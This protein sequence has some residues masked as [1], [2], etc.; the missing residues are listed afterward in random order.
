MATQTSHNTSKLRVL[1]VDDNAMSRKMLEHRFMRDGH[2]VTSVA[3][4]EEALEIVATGKTDIMFLDVQMTGMNGL[5]VLKLIKA[6]AK[7]SSLPVIM[8]SG[9][10]Q[11]DTAAE[12]LKAGAADLLFKPVNK[13]TT[14]E[15]IAI[16]SGSQD[17]P[18]AVSGIVQMDSASEISVAD[19]AVFDNNRLEVLGTEYGRD[20]AD[21]FVRLFFKTA[22]VLC[23]KALA[24][25]E[26]DQFEE[27]KFTV[28][29]LKGSARTLGLFQL[30]AAC[31]NIVHAVE[32]GAMDDAATS[33]RDL[34]KYLERALGALRRRIF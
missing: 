20:K 7:T 27:W 14:R 31:R 21:D 33:T 5:D 23:R 11:A 1:V 17:R 19:A 10:D 6:D 4:G 2:D 16:I 25:A 3:T 15:L 30:A 18:V 12:C 26:A 8:V 9:I 13:E 24:A 28:H 34:P 22:P 32:D 29:D